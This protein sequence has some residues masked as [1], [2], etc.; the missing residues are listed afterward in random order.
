MDRIPLHEQIAY[1]RARAPEY[2]Q[3]LATRDQLGPV[4]Q[5]LRTMGPFEDI[6]ELA[7][8][9]GFWT[10]ELVNLGRTVTAIDASPEMIEI[11]RRRVA[12]TRVVYQHVD[13]F[14]WQ[15]ARD[16]DFLFAAFWLSHVPPT[17]LDNF[18]DTLRR[19]VRPGGQVFVVDQCNDIADDAQGEREG[20]FERR[21]VGDGRTFTIVKVY[22]HPM[23]LAKKFNRDGFETTARR[24]GES[25][26]TILG[27]RR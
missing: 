27:Q 23:L 11:N 9:T 12:D 5:A 3:S 10:R 16:Y 14:A 26:F 13:L 8:G 24:E 4:K 25:F 17:L 22:Y 6:V 18:L 21:T 1:Y 15:P 7:C 2:D 20:I 19:A